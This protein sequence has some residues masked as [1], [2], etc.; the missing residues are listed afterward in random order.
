MKGG[1]ICEGRGGLV[2]I[3][4]DRGWKGGEGGG[5][6]GRQFVRGI[7]K[8]VK[9]INLTVFGKYKKIHQLIIGGGGRGGGGAAQSVRGNYTFFLGDKCDGFGKN[10]SVYHVYPGVSRTISE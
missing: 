3:E 6:T 1:R 8:P 4:R 10:A 2:L 5:R 9:G 7:N